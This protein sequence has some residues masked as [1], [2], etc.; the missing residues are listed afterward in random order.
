MKFNANLNKIFNE[1]EKPFIN[2]M[3]TH[4]VK[5]IENLNHLLETDEY[6]SLSTLEE[7]LLSYYNNEIDIKHVTDYLIYICNNR[8]D[9]KIGI[10]H[11]VY[12]AL[13]E[14]NEETR[15][16]D[17]CNELADAMLKNKKIQLIANTNDLNAF[18]TRFQK[19][20]INKLTKVIN[21][22][23]KEYEEKLGYYVLLVLEILKE[24][25]NKELA[26][27][28]DNQ[29]NIPQNTKTK[30]K[31]MDYKELQELAY[32]NNY[33]YTSSNGSHD[34]YTHINTNKM[35]IIPSHTIGTG[36][37]FAIQKQILQNCN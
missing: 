17:I 30:L 16:G 3:D 1:I 26:E 25:D 5:L 20:S 14:T 34:K 24:E 7:L 12:K 6:Y 32:Q 35:V 21:M 29:Y 33:S 4:T 36:L 2:K 31:Y 22:I 15:F 10:K 27:H 19:Q 11:I 23:T 28:I 13:T 37:S 9:E 18:I 8:D